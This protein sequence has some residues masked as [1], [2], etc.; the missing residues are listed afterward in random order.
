MSRFAGAPNDGREQS[1]RNTSTQ[2]HARTKYART[3]EYEYSKRDRDLEEMIRSYRKERRPNWTRNPQQTRV[4]DSSR[5]DEPRDGK[6]DRPLRK[7]T[8]EFEF[9]NVYVHPTERGKPP[10]GHEN[11]K[12]N[13]INA[14][15]W[16]TLLVFAI[17]CALRI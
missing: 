12:Q 11:K 8:K 10:Q 15:F 4:R 16:S 9:R 2:G 3:K 17:V 5:N 1:Q 6:F 14:A 13:I 7:Y